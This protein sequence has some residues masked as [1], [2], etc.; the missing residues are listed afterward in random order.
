M[1]ANPS[2]VPSLNRFNGDDDDHH[3]HRR[4]LRV[5]QPV[6]NLEGVSDQPLCLQL[7]LIP[8]GL[9]DYFTPKTQSFSANTST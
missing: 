7:L 9:K 5:Q 4:R 2:R 1:D 3:H 8:L 6:G